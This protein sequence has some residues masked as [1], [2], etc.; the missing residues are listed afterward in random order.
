MS[1]AFIFPWLV[2]LGSRPSTT[3]QMEFVSRIADVMAALECNP[4]ISVSWKWGSYPMYS[5]VSS[6]SP[7]SGA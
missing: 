6:M 3:L 7:S 1:S 5:K 2:T 4:K